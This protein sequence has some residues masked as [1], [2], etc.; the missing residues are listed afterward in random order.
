M[1]NTTT[2]AMRVQDLMLEGMTLE[3]AL[4]EV[5]KGNNQ[6]KITDRVAWIS[7]L[8]S[9]SELRKATKIAFA[10]KSKT[11]S[12]SGNLD[13]IARYEEEIR[14]G[15]D[16]LKELLAQATDWKKAIELGE[17]VKGYTN[18][19]IQELEAEVTAKLDKLL[20]GKSK[21]TIKNLIKEQ[22][23]IMIEV[24]EEVQEVF[25]ERVGNRDMRVVT[26][27]KKV[28]LLN[29]LTTETPEKTSRKT[30][31]KTSKKTA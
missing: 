5:M 16:R 30:S 22:P 8:D 12:G 2:M 10:K 11:K 20:E 21:S 25:S 29:S 31:S 6:T 15:Q 24:P 7:S 26:L 4:A 1:M 3:E 14:A 17:D 28:H 13:T 23:D 27:V 9:I 18:M 19:Y